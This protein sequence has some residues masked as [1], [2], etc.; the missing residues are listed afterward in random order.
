M[1]HR[2]SGLLL[3]I[4]SLPSPY[5]IGDFGPSAR[6]FADFLRDTGQRYWQILPLNPINPAQ[7]SSPYT[8]MSA[9]GINTMLISPEKLVEDGLLPPGAIP[10]PE[11]PADHVEYRDVITYKRK[12]Y[13]SSWEHFKGLNE[14]EHWGYNRFCGENSHWLDDYA[15]FVSLKEHHDGA[16]WDQWPRE[17]RD[18]QHEAMTNW[19][20]K[21]ADDINRIKYLQYI[22]ATQWHQVKQYCN[23]MGIH[24]F[25]DLPI[26]VD[27]DSVDVWAHPEIFK[28]ND[29]MKPRK[30]AGV[31]P[32]Y[33]S[34]TGQRWGNPVY[35]WDVLRQRQYDWWIMRMEC[36]LELFDLVRID[37]FRGL[38]AYWEIPAEEE[39]AINGKWV[40]APVYDFLDTL[41][42]R[43]FNLP[44]VAE[45]LGTITADVREVM[46][47]YRLP[48]MKV[49]HFAFGDDNPGHPYLPHNYQ[50]NCVVYTG[51]HDNNTTRGWLEHETSHEMRNRLENYTGRGVDVKA[52]HWDMIRLA[53][54][55]VADM[56]IIPM[57][58][59]L[60]LGQE[61][62]MNT[63]STT[64]GNWRWRM[65][66]EQLNDDITGH[67]RHLTR[68]FGR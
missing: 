7:G 27:Y 1:N 21:L 10:E 37:H 36:N 22:A 17:L 28:L 29:E 41:G 67:L 68:V 45:D 14:K 31:P 8:N 16:S 2:G 64:E 49:L 15:L 57:Q 13:R 18:R 12:L 9:M 38:V 24:V 43:F 55:S 59:I 32:D 34:E 39:T 65:R 63:P 51:T 26:Y 35:N 61:C 44:V 52:V 53:M 19:R 62:R 46:N 33:F 58:D 66:W 20:E 50:T 54:A 56:A 25:G 11:F 48:A 3:H 40:H 4:T 60:G 42:K 5:G 6:R 23:N 30:V 47:H